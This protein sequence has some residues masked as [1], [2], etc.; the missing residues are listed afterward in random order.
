MNE[1]EVVQDIADTFMSFCMPREKYA[2]ALVFAQEVYD[3]K[4]RPI[5]RDTYNEGRNAN[6]ED[7]N[8]YEG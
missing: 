6:P 1:D 3:I 4:M 8:P 2:D 5:L 7:P